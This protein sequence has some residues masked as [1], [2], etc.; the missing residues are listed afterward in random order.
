MISGRE[1]H[2]HTIDELRP[3][4]KVIAYSQLP[5]DVP[6]EALAHTH[7]GDYH[8]CDVRVRRQFE[9]QS[10]IDAMSFD[11]IVQPRDLIRVQFRLD[12]IDLESS[13]LV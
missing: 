5:I 3:E 6:F 2:Q 10:A 12:N 1:K 7:R 11:E 13:V 9:V 8:I 4:E